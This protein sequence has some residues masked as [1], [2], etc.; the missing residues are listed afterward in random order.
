[1]PPRDTTVLRG[2]T[3]RVYRFLFKLGRPAGIREVQRGLGLSSPSV[4]EYHLRK[5]TESGLVKNDS[6]GYVVE[7][8]VWED[9]VRMRRTVIPV[10]A[11]YII[12]FA[13]ALLIYIVFFTANME[14][15]R[16]GLGVIAAALLVS[17][18]ELVRT[19]RQS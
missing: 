7:R 12:F 14:G 13:A 1:L 4:A 18:F 17:V 15:Y 6:E 8:V 5:L 3:L 2:T 16:F 11:F 10:Q 9:M 19:S